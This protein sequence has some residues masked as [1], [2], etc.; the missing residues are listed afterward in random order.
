MKR[1]KTNNKIKENQKTSGVRFQKSKDQMN[2]VRL[3]EH[4]HLKFRYRPRLTK[5]ASIFLL[6]LT[7]LV[8]IVSL[9]AMYYANNLTHYNFIFWF[10][11]ILCLATVLGWP[12]VMALY[13]LPEEK[14]ACFC[15]MKYF[16]RLKEPYLVIASYSGYCPHCNNSKL[17]LIFNF[18]GSLIKRNSYFA[19]CH[20]K[21]E[22]T[23]TPDNLHLF[24]ERDK[25]LHR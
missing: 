22:H 7:P 9:F 1:R 16:L 6:V 25:K 5:I 23:Y 12:M 2:P 4:E 21:P 13:R 18:P 19:K 3:M 10:G 20:A 17:N 11:F 14:F 24:N 15:F 8:F